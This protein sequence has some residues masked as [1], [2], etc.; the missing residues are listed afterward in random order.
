MAGVQSP[1]DGYARVILI[2]EVAFVPLCYGIY[3]YLWGPRLR[4]QYAVD[5]P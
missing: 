3:V 5:L 4:Y 2:V 1:R